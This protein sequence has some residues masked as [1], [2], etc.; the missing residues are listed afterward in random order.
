MPDSIKPGRPLS[1][2]EYEDIK[3]LIGK[4]T[5]MIKG[6]YEREMKQNNVIKSLMSFRDNFQLPIEG[7][8]RQV[9]G[10]SGVH[11]NFGVMKSFEFK[12]RSMKTL[13]SFSFSFKIPPYLDGQSVEVLINGIE[14]ASFKSNGGKIEGAVAFEMESN[15]TAEFAFKFAR[16]QSAHAAGQGSDKRE[17]SGFIERLRCE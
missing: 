1:I 5:G 13:S 2:D 10:A 16:S 14:L 17:V 9:G 6:M 4:R 15:D 3:Q 8:V 7:F 12:L 11:G